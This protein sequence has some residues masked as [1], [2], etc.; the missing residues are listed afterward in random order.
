MCASVAGVPP[1]KLASWPT[2]LTV[3][4]PVTAPVASRGTLNV[5]VTV[6][7][8][9]ASALVIG[10]TWLAALSVA[11]KVIGPVLLDGVVG[12][13]LPHAAAISSAAAIAA[14]RFMSS[15]RPEPIEPSNPDS[16]KSP[17]EI[18]PQA[19]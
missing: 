16:L 5:I 8:A 19:E 14:H 15:L 7:R 10:G 17:N 11:V 3:P 2:K 13:S 1:G 9:L 18:E 12:L 6:P 4:A